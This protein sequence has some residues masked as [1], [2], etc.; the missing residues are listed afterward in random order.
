MRRRVFLAQTAGFTTLIAGCTR[1]KVGLKGWVDAKTDGIKIH[2]LT[3]TNHHI[4]PHDLEVLITVGNDI[5]YWDSKEITAWDPDPDSISGATFKNVPTERRK[6]VVSARLA[7]WP[8]E[9]WEQADFKDDQG[10][11]L[12]VFL[13]IGSPGIHDK[14][15]VTILDN[16]CKNRTDE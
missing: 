9:R 10:S 8:P 7:D 14:E 11:C 1:G 15:N 3:A 6:Y 16:R 5:V 4:E 13:Y 2:S 12:N